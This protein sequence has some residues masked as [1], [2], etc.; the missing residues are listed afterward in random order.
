MEYK[1]VDKAYT[2]KKYQ[3]INNV[4]KKREER[5]YRRRLRSDPKFQE[6][7]AKRKWM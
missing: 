7:E 5:E 2:F 4:Y 3:D 1:I 6:E